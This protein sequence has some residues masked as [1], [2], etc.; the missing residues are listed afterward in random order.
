MPRLKNILFKYHMVNIAMR[1]L[2]KIYLRVSQ[3]S[4]ISKP[5]C[6]GSAAGLILS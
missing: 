4:H 6:R 5:I 1:F 2:N 3:L